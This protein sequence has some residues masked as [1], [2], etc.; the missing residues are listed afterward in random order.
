MAPVE[1]DTQKSLVAFGRTGLRTALELIEKP[2]L[3]LGC[4]GYVR[5]VCDRI[6]D[7]VERG[8]DQDIGITAM[9]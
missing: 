7:R 4:N 9:S 6:V 3:A 2:V 1:H 5:L 8:V